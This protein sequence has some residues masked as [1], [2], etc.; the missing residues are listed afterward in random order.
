MANRSKPTKGRSRKRR[1][2]AAAAA[3][4]ASL[5]SLFTPSLSPALPAD[6]RALLEEFDG[7]AGLRNGL[8]R[9]AADRDEW[10]GIPIPLEGER[11]IIEPSYP[12]AQLS[13][14]GEEKPNAEDE[15]LRLRNA[16]YSTKLRCLVLVIEDKG[17]V[18][19][20]LKP[21][22]HH[23]TQD[24]RTLG[25]SDAW[26]I[27][28]ESNATRTLAE[29]VS[30]RQFKQYMLTGMF[31]ESSKR[32]GLHYL[33]KRL[34]PTV[35]IGKDPRRDTLR[36]LCSLCMHPI[37]YYAGSWAGAMCPTDDVIA[38]LMMMRGDEPMLWRRSSQHPA[39]A[40][41]AGL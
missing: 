11:L 19:Y 35:A 34:K 5:P 7:L 15:G 24:L 28:Q 18:V 33:F 10:A 20:G 30:H 22:V 12:Y 41:E 16:F 39:W 36:V 25:C 2:S 14:V 37:A 17:R 31:M 9:L 13:K 6:K 21:A 32:S 38:H 23:L 4:S 29:L 27:E 8:R 1:H 40:P 3:A 26:G